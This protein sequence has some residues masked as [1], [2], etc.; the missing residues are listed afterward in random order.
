MADDREQLE[1]VM[2]LMGEGSTRRI[3]LS[4]VAVLA[5]SGIVLQGL[6]YW[7][8]AQPAGR[9]WGALGIQVWAFAVGPWM[10]I[11]GLAL[12]LV[13]KRLKDMQEGSDLGA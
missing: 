6:V 1:R 9:E 8:A 11:V 5:L 10:L 7:Y 4:A 3:R 12:A 2:E 13:W